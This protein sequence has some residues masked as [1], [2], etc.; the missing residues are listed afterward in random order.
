[1][2]SEQKK[3]VSLMRIIGILNYQ[4]LQ[5]KWFLLGKII[6]L[7]IHFQPLD[8]AR[9]QYKFNATEYLFVF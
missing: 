3:N 1:M 8:A 2:A 5:M 7:S 9:I 6:F 4:Q